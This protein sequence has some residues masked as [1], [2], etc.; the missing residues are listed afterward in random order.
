MNPCVSPHSKSTSLC[1]WCQISSDLWLTSELVFYF[2][3]WVIHYAVH[4]SDF[5]PGSFCSAQLDSLYYIWIR[6]EICF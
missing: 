1:P 3:N 4:V 2:E 5:L 6:A